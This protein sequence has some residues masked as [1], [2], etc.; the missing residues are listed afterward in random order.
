MVKTTF[1][2]QKVRSYLHNLLVERGQVTAH[3]SIIHDPVLERTAPVGILNDTLNL[4]H[5]GK[6]SSA[7]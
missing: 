7:S 3:V 1:R 5:E 6:T 4:L 2:Q